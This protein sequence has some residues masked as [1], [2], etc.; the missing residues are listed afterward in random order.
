MRFCLTIRVNPPNKVRGCA[1]TGGETGTETG[2]EERQGMHLARTG[3]LAAGQWNQD[4]GIWAGHY[5][6]LLPNHA[7]E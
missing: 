1:G 5:P 3:L 4:T 7:T 6:T 2:P